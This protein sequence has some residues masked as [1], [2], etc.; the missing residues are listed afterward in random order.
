MSMK[1]ASFG[2]MQPAIESGL[3][4]FRNWPC[5]PFSLQLADFLLLFPAKP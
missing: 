4:F 2:Q 3:L 5:W 1:I